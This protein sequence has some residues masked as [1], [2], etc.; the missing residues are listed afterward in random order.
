M[1]VSNSAKA[2]REFF[3]YIHVYIN[4]IPRYLHLV[5]K[6]SQLRKTTCNQCTFYL[7][8]N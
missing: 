7:C 6:D 1:S 5:L 3:K 4:L 2:V 8:M